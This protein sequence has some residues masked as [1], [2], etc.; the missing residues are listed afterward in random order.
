M[1]SPTDHLTDTHTPSVTPDGEGEATASTTP[2]A[3]G[4]GSHAA[5]RVVRALPAVVGL[6]VLAYL[7][8]VPI[9]LPGVLPGRVNGP[10]SMQLLAT[11]LVIGGIALSYDVLFG[12]TGLLSFGHALFVAAGSYLLTI[13][14]STWALPLALAVPVALGLSTLLAVVVGGIALRVGGIAF[15]MVTLAFAQAASIIVMRN[16]GG[17][18]GG[19]EGRPLDRAAV[20]DVLVGV[21]NAPYRF[22][23]ALAFVVVAWAV[24]TLLVRSRA[25]HA[26]AAVRENEQRAAVLGFGTYRVKLLAIVVGSFLGALGGVVHALVLGGSNPHLTTSEFT[27]SLLVMVVLGGAGSRWGAVIGGVLYTYADAR[28][29]EVSNAA[30]LQDLPVVVRQVLSQ[31]LFILGVFFVV[32]VYFAPSGLTGLGG[33]LIRRSGSR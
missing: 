24:V 29:V 3:S 19:E 6:A 5:R 22:W 4:E 28:L 7:P 18:T 23:L 33:R 14:L 21:A 31:P 32:V 27:L 9:E 10:G 20:P 15:A 1:T 26:M 12:R 2:T 16:P 13:S 25:G 30:V 8:Y 11:C 17:V